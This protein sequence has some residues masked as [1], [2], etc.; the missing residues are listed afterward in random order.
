[1]DPMVLGKGFFGLFKYT[2]LIKA[3]ETLALGIEYT[4]IIYTDIL[5]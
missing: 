3:A 1:M 2:V 5:C 4:Q